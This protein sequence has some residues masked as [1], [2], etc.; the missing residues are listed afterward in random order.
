[1]SPEDDESA[2]VRRKPSDDM[3]KQR[4]KLTHLLATPS[5]SQNIDERRHRAQPLTALVGADAHAADQAE[6]CKSH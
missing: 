3:W 4:R 2:F 6:T 1:M 5:L